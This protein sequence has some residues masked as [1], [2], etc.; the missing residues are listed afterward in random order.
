MKFNNIHEQMH[1]LIIAAAIMCVTLCACTPQAHAAT[2]MEDALFKGNALVPPVVAIAD[3]TVQHCDAC[4]EPYAIGEPSP[5]R[6]TQFDD[7][8]SGLACNYC[9][10]FFA[11][12]QADRDTLRAHW[13][14]E[15]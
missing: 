14:G 5:F 12:D 11:L 13:R 6:M 7:G 15:L 3:G 8:T 10:A 4:G 9:I 2:N 1:I